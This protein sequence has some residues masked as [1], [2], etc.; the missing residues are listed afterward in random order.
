VALAQAL[1]G[2]LRC[3]PAQLALD[4]N[5]F[6]RWFGLG[7]CQARDRLVVR[8]AKS[9][10]MGVPLESAGG[11]RG[12]RRALELVPAVHRA[13]AGAAYARLDRLFYTQL[14]VSSRLT[15]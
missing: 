5:D 9:P 15:R 4:A 11:D 8:D 2:R 7:E 10:R 14:L 1:S 3:L 6:V 13:F 12:D